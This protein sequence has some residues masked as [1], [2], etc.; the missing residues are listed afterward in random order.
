M[1]KLLSLMNEQQNEYDRALA[2]DRQK[3]QERKRLEQQRLDNEKRIN[4]AIEFARARTERLS[5]FFFNYLI[6]PIALEDVRQLKRAKMMIP[7]MSHNLLRLFEF[8]LLSQLGQGLR[9]FFD[10]MIVL[11]YFYFFLILSRNLATF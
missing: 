6:I 7:I 9:D 8:G 4:E 3:A 1:T 10:K 11:K 2:I 5:R